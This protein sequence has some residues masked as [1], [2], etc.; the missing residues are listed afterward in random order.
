MIVEKGKR[1]FFDLIGAA[2]SWVLFFIY[3]KEVIE[4]VEFEPNLMLLYGTIGITFLWISIYTLSG[5]YI[6]VR[7]VSRLNEFY[8]TISQSIIGCLIIFFCFIIDDIEYYQNYTTYYQS[9]FTLTSLH[10]CI[11]F[12]LRYII[13][14]SIVKKIQNK[15]IT[16]KTIIIGKGE[17][18]NNVFNSLISMSRSTGNEIIGYI[19]I[20]DSKLLNTRI[21]NLGKLLDL[22]KIIEEQ[23]IEEVLIHRDIEAIA[24]VGHRP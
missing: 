10:F 23:Q 3:R 5:N 4:N 14:N 12:F 16:F 8:R 9:L 6:D 19:D 7:R 20:A 1:I 15:K 11:T 17:N 22:E 13:T 2:I 18:I 21:K 24:V